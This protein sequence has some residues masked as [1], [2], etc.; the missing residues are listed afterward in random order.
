MSPP[1]QGSEAE[2]LPP[3]A[4]EAETVVVVGSVVAMLRGRGEV[5]VRQRPRCGMREGGKVERDEHRVCC[6]GVA[7][8]VTSHLVKRAQDVC[9]EGKAE[10]V[11]CLL[12]LLRREAGPMMR[13]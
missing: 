3:V 8:S 10:W 13:G 9:K 6:E 12:L 4:K 7:G 2:T 11:T 5:T 1:C